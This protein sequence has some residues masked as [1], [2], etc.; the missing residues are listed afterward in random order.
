MVVVVVVVVVVWG[1]APGGVAYM[2]CR[3]QL[4]DSCSSQRRGSFDDPLA[5]GLLCVCSAPLAPENRGE[6]PLFLG[7]CS[8]Q[9]RSSMR[10]PRCSLVQ[11]ATR[12]LLLTGLKGHLGPRPA[13]P[14]S[15]V[16]CSFPCCRPSFSCWP[17]RRSHWAE[18]AA[19]QLRRRGVL[20]VVLDSEKDGRR[21]LED[22]KE[23]VLCPT[24]A[25]SPPQQTENIESIT[26][27]I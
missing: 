5:Y 3:S 26:S 19:W 4:S 24:R 20:P 21:G 1:M 13:W 12:R 9:K 27:A 2:H 22:Y 11:G 14:Q 25:H 8:S 23:G 18:R 16:S 10:D 7:R 15:L 17:A 6:P